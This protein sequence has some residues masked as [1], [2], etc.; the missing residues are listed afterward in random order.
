MIREQQVAADGCRVLMVR[1]AFQTTASAAL[2]ANP[3]T[4][5]NLK[6][7]PLPP[8]EASGRIVGLLVRGG[9]AA[10]VDNFR[11]IRQCDSRVSRVNHRPCRFST[12]PASTWLQSG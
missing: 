1:K 11:R 10:G 4:G 6:S 3:P 12:T 2:P 8:H 7:T 5:G 9:C